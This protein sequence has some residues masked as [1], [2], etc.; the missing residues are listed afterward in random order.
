M[1][2]S[3]QGGQDHLLL[4]RLLA[5]QGLAHGGG[6]GVGRLRCRQDP[7]GADELHGSGKALRLRDGDGLHHA[8]LID[9]RDERG[10][11]VVAEAA[12]VDRVGDEVVAERV[13]LH[14]RGHAG[15]VAEVV[16]V[17]TPGERR[18]GCRL[19]R[20]DGRVH[21]SGHLLA[22]EREGE[23]AEVGSA[24]GAADQQVRGFLPRLGQLQQ[25]LF[26]DDGLVHQHVVEDAAEGVA[27]LGV[28]CGDLD[29]LAD[30]DPEGAGAVRISGQD[31]PTGRS[32][33]AG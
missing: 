14:Q 1:A 13:H 19:H 29:G 15:C 5:Q 7:L 26:S 23:S 8:Q 9:V 33:V 28:R 24:T 11:A 17:D 16:G 32:Q 6:N 22:Q 2:V 27:G 3:A 10:H 25:R 30:S 31:G 21:L 18:T 12:G 20:P 4:T